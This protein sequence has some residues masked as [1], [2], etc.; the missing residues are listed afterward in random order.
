M[1]TVCKRYKKGDHIQG[2]L[3]PDNP[4]VMVLDEGRLSVIWVPITFAIFVLFSVLPA[5][6]LVRWKLR[7]LR[8]TA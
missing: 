1:N 2:T 5:F 8:R 6:F 3:L 4:T 7:K